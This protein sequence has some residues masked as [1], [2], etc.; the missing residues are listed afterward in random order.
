MISPHR[1]SPWL[2][3]IALGALLTLSRPAA[4]AVYQYSVPMPRSQER[5]AYLWIPPQCQR[6]RGLIVGLQNMLEKPMLEDPEIRRAAEDSGLGI[7]WIAPGSEG[8]GTPLGP[9][10]SPA[11]DSVRVLQA[12]LNALADESGYSEVANAPLLPVGHSAASPFV[13]GLP[14]RLPDRVF[15]CLPY[16]GSYP[17]R[18]PLGV[19]T[20]HVSSEWAEWG[21]EWGNAWKRRDEPALRKL[22]GADELCLLGELADIGAGHFTWSPETA[23]VLA[24]FIR[25]AAL[26][27]LP[28][29]APLA[30]PVTL[31]PISHL[32]GVLVDPATLGTPECK[33]VAYADWVGDPKRAYWY[34]DA[35]LAREV[36]EFMSKRLVRKP[37]AVTFLQ[38]G[39]PAALEQNGFAELLPEFLKDGVTFQVAGQFLDRSPTPNLYGG[40]KLGRASKMVRF[41][42]GSGGL[43]QVGPDLFRVRLDRGGVGRQGPPW[44]PWVLAHHPGNDDYRAADRPARIRINTRNTAGAPQA[45]HFEAIPSQR[46]GA[47]SVKLHARSDSGLPVQFFVISGPAEVEGDTLKLQPL[48]PRSRHPARVLV[49]AYQWG[50]AT[51]PQIQSAGPVIREFAIEDKAGRS[52]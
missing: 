40:G 33:P 21:P 27:R 35:E 6:V 29:T 20:L 25:K 23:Q 12:T 22:R 39:Q 11:A 19:P 44:E 15:A 34:F 2:S 45:L 38:S 7:V 1:R 3:L 16:K 36:N 42:V 18:G 37:Q 41:R 9:D 32:S 10:F 47:R 13:W 26:Y 24:G 43:E 52:K 49:A 28:D 30:G 8:E 50:R 46:V 14:G 4:A 51:A 5:R 17:A 31:K 48:P